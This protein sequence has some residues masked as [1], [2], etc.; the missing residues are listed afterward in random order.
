MK[1]FILFAATFVLLCCAFPMQ[2]Q[3]A[4]L[5]PGQGASGTL[6]PNGSMTYTFDLPAKQD[7]V[8]DFSSDKTVWP[9]Y[10]Y[11]INGAQQCPPGGGG[12]DDEPTVR[13][14]DIPARDAAQTIELQLLRPSGY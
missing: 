13:V 12:G 1:R 11:V 4:H 9:T 10:C 5:S 6:N 3:A 8:V 2:A 14:F 7:M